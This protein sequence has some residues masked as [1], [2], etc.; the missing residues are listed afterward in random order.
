MPL[1]SNGMMEG[2][3]PCLTMS[4]PVATVAPQRVHC[5]PRAVGAAIV[6]TSPGADP[7]I[8]GRV[9][10][11]LREGCHRIHD[12]HRATTGHGPPDDPRGVDAPDGPRRAHASRA[13]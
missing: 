13:R 2:V 4:L 9:T 1:M 12:R 3:L 6:P 5:R 7:Q 8:D 11:G 10:S